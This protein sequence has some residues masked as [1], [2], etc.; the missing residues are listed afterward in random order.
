[1][2]PLS[3]S[4]ELRMASRWLLLALL[5]LLVAAPALS[6]RGKKRAKKAAD[7]TEA[8][9]QVLATKA[10]DQKKGKKTIAEFTDGAEH[11]EGYFDLYWQESSGHLFLAIDKFDQEFL[12]SE[13]LAAGIG[14][15]DIGLDRGQ[16]D[17]GRV[18]EFRRV[19]PK[20]LLVQPNYRYRAVSDSELERR[21]VK[22]AFAESVLAGFEV[23]AE[24]DGR[25]LI[26]VTDF[27]LRDSHGVAATLERS[28]QGNYSPD[29]SRSAIY[30]PLTKA[31]PK[32]TEIEATLTFTGKPKGAWIRSVAPSPDAVTV[33]THHSFVELPGPGFELREWDAR[34]G[35][36]PVSFYDYATPIDEPLVKRYTMRH[37]L[38]KKDPSAAVSE[39]VEPIIYYLDPGTPEPIRSA[40]LDGARW[41]NQAFE[42]AGYRDAFQVEML[43]ADA[44]PMDVRYNLIQWVHRSTRGW[45]YGG[46]VTDPR[47]G[48]IIKGKV[49]LGS[50]R[51]RQD[52]LIAEGLL[53]PYGE[54]GSGS[55]AMNEMAL[56]R[57]RQLSAHEVGHTI[58]L[59]HNF[60]ASVTNRAS[61]MDYPHPRVILD[62]EGNVSLVEAYD[63]DIGEWDA[64]AI[65]WGY[66]DFAPGTQEASALEGILE[67]TREQGQLFITDQDARPPGGAHPVAHLWDGGASAA[68]ELDRMMKVRAKALEQF[69]ERNVPIGTPLALLEETLV[70]TYLF[71]RYQL[72]AAVK[73]VG[74]LDYTYA[75]RGDGQ[76]PIS[77]VSPAEQRKALASVLATL[78]PAALT[79]SD[80]I[81][82][83]VPPRA[84]G[85]RRGRENFRGRTDVVFDPVGAAEVA[86]DMTL[87]L[88]L[89]PARA[90]RLV[91]LNAYDS[92]QPGFNEVLDA[93]LAE[94]VRAA[95]PDGLAGEVKRAID[96]L[97]VRHLMALIENDRTSG[98]A[99]SIAL[100]A[101]SELESSLAAVDGSGRVHAQGLAWV[102]E[103]YRRD[104][105]SVELPDPLP[106]PD[107]SPIGSG[108]A[109]SDSWCGFRGAP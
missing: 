16:M 73:V 11:L 24:T 28:G 66:S 12:Y 72:E 50:L 8:A 107:G 56:A 64:R 10:G 39:A 98:H 3:A 29:K 61:V 33:R 57:L 75:H 69:G 51:V 83:V 97:V 40:L 52:F 79:L 4:C 6:Q 2:K 19:G 70:P 109:S 62:E 47:T 100:H 20:V 23:K 44:D 94:T 54:D 105:S 71:H 90:S 53:A 92:S 87:S 108:L 58:G 15:N 89:H 42:A 35:F 95:A 5:L 45:S 13:S 85:F 1:M 41:W 106:T 82:A 38:K 32:N 36:I 14:S 30:P 102:I 84:A 103:R 68:E 18:V 17:G 86:A 59:Q 88:L 65:V 63:T 49:T 21:S 31:F 7:A 43:P 60:A 22:E 55:D 104:P 37:R 101:L 81:L 27:V 93:L 25:V 99:R 91:N 26:D 80:Q 9:R 78:D 67:E 96:H 48:E 77:L 74:G 76:V 46:A 34:S